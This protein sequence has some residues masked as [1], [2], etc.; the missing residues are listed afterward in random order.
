[1]LPT[2]N[3]RC[4]TRHHRMRTAPAT[5]GGRRV[6][7]HRAGQGGT[8]ERMLGR[9]T[10]Y[11]I[12]MVDPQADGDTEHERSRDICEALIRH[13]VKCHKTERVTSH[14]EVG[15]TLMAQA[16]AF[17]A[18]VLVMGCYGHSRLREFVFGGATRYALEK[19][20]IPVLMS[21]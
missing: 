10:Y 11:S 8:A 12:L 19:M 17:D 9:K 3:E 2:V 21:H 18:D 20:A 1:M 16:E 6:D 14:A 13:G 5:S 4:L 7:A 15:P